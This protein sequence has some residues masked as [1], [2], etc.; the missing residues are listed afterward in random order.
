[1]YPTM[2]VQARAVELIEYNSTRCPNDEGRKWDDLYG[3]KE[4]DG[5]QEQ[6][7]MELQAH[8]K[9]LKKLPPFEA[10]I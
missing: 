9:S 1:M 6:M 4:I 7:T 10:G 2:A 3:N 5:K 8:L